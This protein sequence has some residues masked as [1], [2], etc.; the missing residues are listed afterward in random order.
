VNGQSLVDGGVANPLPY[1][2]IQEDCDI[3]IAIDVSG[4]RNLPDGETLS[5]IG[6]LTQSFT[7]MSRNILLEKLKWQQPAV[8]IKPDIR[9]VKVLEFYKAREVFEQARPAQQQLKKA[10][11]KAMR[12]YD[13]RPGC[14]TG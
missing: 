12:R 1:D 3:V 8:Y 9:N 14:T 5:S 6:V 11:K 4:N 10:L 7:A 2:L 13:G